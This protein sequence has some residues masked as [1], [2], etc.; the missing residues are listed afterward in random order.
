MIAG[1]VAGVVMCA[2]HLDGLNERRRS[3]GCELDIVY[4]VSAA[5]A[6]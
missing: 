5:K 1:L 6:D 3:T 4:M 2:F